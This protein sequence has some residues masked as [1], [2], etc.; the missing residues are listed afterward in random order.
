MRSC[1]Q[2][3]LSYDDVL[4]LKEVED[5]LEVYYN[6]RQFDNAI[7]YLAENYES[8]FDMY[9]Q[10]GAAMAADTE[11]GAAKSR[12][13]RYDFLYNYGRKVVDNP[14][15]FMELLIHDAYL[16]DNCKTETIICQKGK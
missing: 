14:D 15:L 10:I 16:R 6:S 9:R 13:K 12:L 7:S 2:E 1:P 11:V 5:A 3:W 4:L 8:P